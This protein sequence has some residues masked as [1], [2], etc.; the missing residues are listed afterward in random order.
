[1]NGA[2]LAQLRA[3]LKDGL[4]R[5]GLTKTQLAA[6]AEL[7]RTTVHDALREGAPAPTPATVAALA[8]ALRL[9]DGELLDQLRRVTDTASAGTECSRGHPGLGRPILG[10]DPHDLE[11]HPAGPAAGT[12][13][14]PPSAS[15]RRALPGYVTRDHDQLLDEAVRDAAEGHSHMLVLVGTS[16]TGKTRA[17]WEAVQRLADQDWLLWHPFDPSR[18]QAALE[19]L[20]RVRPKTVVWLNEAQHYLGDSQAGEQIAAALHNLLTRPERGPIL[21]LG[22]LWP[23]YAH[24][25]MAL[26]IPGHS[27]PHSR[28]REL[29]AG[30]TLIVP[31]TFNSLALN[32][33]ATLAASGDQLL[34][35]ALTRVQDHGRLAQDLA[36]AP[37]LLN[38]YQ[39]VTPAARAI[40]EA[41]MDARR[42]GVS[43]NLP[44]A[45]LTDAATDYLSD[46]D[47]DQ[48]GEDWAEQ[49]YAEL[50]RP[51]HGKQAPLRRANTRPKRRTP[52]DPTA[53][54]PLA[55]ASGPSFRLAD[56][57]EQHGRTTR[58]SLCPPASFWHAAH[59][60]LAD[61]SD[62]G[63]LIRAADDRHRLQWAHH[64][65]RKAAD[66]GNVDALFQLTAF[67]ETAGDRRTAEQMALRAAEAGNPHAL[68][69]LATMRETAGDR[70]GAEQ[71]AQRAADIGSP[72]ALAR[73]AII[74]QD[75]QLA[76][77]AADAGIP[78]ILAVLAAVQGEALD[79]QG[80]EPPYRAAFDAKNFPDRVNG[81][82]QVR[83]QAGDWQGAEPIAQRVAE[84]SNPD[85]LVRLA[86]IREE[87]GDWHEVQQLH[88]AAAHAGNDNAR[89]R[90]V[91]MREEGDRQ[92]AED[93]ARQVANA[94]GG[95]SPYF[96]KSTQHDRWP[97]GLDPDGTPTSPW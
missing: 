39:S 31:D 86:A 5:S 94:G 47:F 33:A 23:E 63:N 82:V 38:R 91:H 3:R 40:L 65:R 17:C 28:T 35:D 83:L 59:A 22:T 1:M 15:A 77:R 78:A 84:T 60:H 61:P 8:R 37:E 42:L 71:I 76:Q 34:A 45:F 85:A 26:P 52:G 69:L 92:E 13:A 50:A 66:A 79:G 56:Y 44:Q 18:A 2:E 27:D 25:Y 75:S 10:W 72:H 64:L 36:G 4:A 12:D 70:Q 97:H 14:I 51:V 32:T 53:K 73:L 21:V 7:G 62:L 41:A 68:D 6:R 93:L 19:E 11:V 81:L 95:R 24:Q 54:G 20:H 30:R 88:R 43:L 90:L 55:S 67:W 74:R 48:L 49:A 96:S 87:V 16:S 9:R 57:L 89:G 46:Q 58:T 80:T 29:L